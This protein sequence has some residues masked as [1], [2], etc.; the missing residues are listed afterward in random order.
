MEQRPL[1]VDIRRAGSFREDAGGLTWL[2]RNGV[3]EV[4]ASQG[5]P[6]GSTQGGLSF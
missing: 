6:W 4:G 2:E 3:R 1:V 5:W